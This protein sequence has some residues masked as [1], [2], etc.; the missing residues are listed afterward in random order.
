MTTL[1]A[2]LWADRRGQDIT[3]YAL[4]GGM[5]ASIAVAIV[6]ELFAIVQHVG[7]VLL[8]VTQACAQYAR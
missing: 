5:V 4:M 7:E 6:P 8:S 1:L 2:N 3:E